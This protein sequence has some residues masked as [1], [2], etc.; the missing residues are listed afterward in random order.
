MTREYVTS[1]H[2]LMD[3]ATS[4]WEVPSGSLQGEDQAG[5]QGGEGVPSRGAACQ[6]AKVGGTCSWEGQRRAHWDGR[7][8]GPLGGGGRDDLAQPRG[9]QGQ[10]GLYQEHREAW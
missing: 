5:Q 9:A 8:R 1:A 6:E 3:L 4:P 10:F 2:V 7:L